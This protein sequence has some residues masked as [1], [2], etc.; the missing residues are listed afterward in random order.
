MK[1]RSTSTRLHGATSQKS[2]QIKNRL[3]VSLQKSTQKHQY[4]VTSPSLKQGSVV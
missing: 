3:V 4:Q 1:R 2:L